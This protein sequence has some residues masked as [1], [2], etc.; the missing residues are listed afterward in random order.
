MNL[1]GVRI[2]VILDEIFADSAGPDVFRLDDCPP[3]FELL[4]K[5]RRLDCLRLRR[6]VRARP[7]SRAKNNERDERGAKNASDA[8][9]DRRIEYRARYSRIGP[10]TVRMIGLWAS[11]RRGVGRELEA[12]AEDQPTSA[13]T[14][15]AV[16]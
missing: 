2:G 10:A 9:A 5:I 4:G 15:S 13:S 16:T 11:R 7:C 12:V 3:P 8:H 1:P 6:V 14:S